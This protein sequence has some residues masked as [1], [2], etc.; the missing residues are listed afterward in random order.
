MWSSL[1]SWC[2]QRKW[3]VP[4]RQ[5]QQFFD[6]LTIIA[7]IR[8]IV[9]GHQRKFHSN[10]L[11]Y[12]DHASR[13]YHQSNN[14]R[15]IIASQQ[16]DIVFTLVCG[17][18]CWYSSRNSVSN[19]ITIVLHVY[20]WSKAKVWNAFMRWRN[21]KWR[22]LENTSDTFKQEMNCSGYYCTSLS[23]LFQWSPINFLCL[24]PLKTQ[25]SRAFKHKEI[26]LRENHSK[27]GQAF[28]AYTW[29]GHRR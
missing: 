17:G 4:S 21:S 14:I 7:R 18:R 26:L 27:V 9:M 5:E 1:Q 16:S 10:W 23:E 6:H 22:K 15:P 20:S 24:Y 19:S 11:R 8:S 29:L 12:F 28:L 3:F 2:V 13:N 25:I